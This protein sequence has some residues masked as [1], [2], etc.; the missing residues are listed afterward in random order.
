MTVIKPDPDLTQAITAAIEGTAAHDIQLSIKVDLEGEEDS[1]GGLLPIPEG[2]SRI[3][4][5]TFSNVLVTDEAVVPDTLSYKIT[6]I[7]SG[8][9]ITDF[10]VSP[11]T[12]ASSIFKH[13]ISAHENRIINQANALEA[14]KLT[15]IAEY[16]TSQVETKEVDFTVQNLKGILDDS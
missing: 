10:Q 7:T 9:I 8:E 16:G 15:F 6:D 13:I 14:R 11:F 2:S 1:S 4:K 3:L 12:P 5:L